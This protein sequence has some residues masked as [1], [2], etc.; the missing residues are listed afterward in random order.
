LKEER[1]ALINEFASFKEKEPYGTLQ[2]FYAYIAEKI[3]KGEVN[4]ET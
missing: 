4:G 3:N 2:D 1:E